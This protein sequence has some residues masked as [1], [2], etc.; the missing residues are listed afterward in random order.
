MQNSQKFATQWR[1]SKTHLQFKKIKYPF[2]LYDISWKESKQ[3]K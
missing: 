2:Y 1:I 3:T